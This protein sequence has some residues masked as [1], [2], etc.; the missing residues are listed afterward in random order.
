MAS[1]EEV[2]FLI[3]FVAMV[4]LLLY[5]ISNVLNNF[6]SYPMKDGFI[7][8][9]LFSICWGITLFVRIILYETVITS[10]LFMLGN[11]LLGLNTMIFIIELLVSL[12]RSVYSQ[13]RGRYEP[14]LKI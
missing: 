3:S 6:E 13:Y 11:G 8:F 1:M 12:S 2:V 14:E 9:I 10:V 5:K 7:H 4:M